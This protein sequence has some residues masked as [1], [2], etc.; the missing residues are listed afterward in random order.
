MA[1]EALKNP[2]TEDMVEVDSPGFRYAVS[3][4]PFNLRAVR[5]FVKSQ[6]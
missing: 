1:L 4:N 5:R 2:K 6:L 3:K